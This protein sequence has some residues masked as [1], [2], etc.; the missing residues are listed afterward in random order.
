MPYTLLYREA[1]E[2]CKTV[3]EAIDLID[4]DATPKRE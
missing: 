2:R 3:N 1:L 4:G